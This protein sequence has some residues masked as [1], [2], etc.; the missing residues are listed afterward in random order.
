MI[1]RQLIISGDVVVTSLGVVG[2]LLLQKNPTETKVLNDSLA[3]MSRLVV[4]IFN[5]I[6]SITGF[7]LHITCDSL[8]YFYVFYQQAASDIKSH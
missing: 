6:D 4:I 5:R 8:V 7:F 2:V 1:I 3:T